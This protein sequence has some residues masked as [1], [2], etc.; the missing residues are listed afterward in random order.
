MADN[1]NRPTP[2]IPSV[3]TPVTRRL[4]FIRDTFL[5]GNPATYRMPIRPRSY[6]PELQNDGFFHDDSV[7]MLTLFEDMLAKDGVIYGILEQRRAAVLARP[8]AIIPAGQEPRD[9]EVGTFVQECL[10]H[11]GGADGGFD[12]DLYC[13]LDGIWKGVS[14]QEIEWAIDPKDKRVRP[15][16]LLHRVPANFRFDK[17]GRLFL[18]NMSVTSASQPVDDR[19]YIVFRFGGAYENPYGCGLLQRLWWYYEFKLANMRAWQVRNEKFGSPTV[20]AKLPPGVTEELKTATET[21]LERISTD[22]SFMVPDSVVVELLEAEMKAQGASDPYRNL[23]EYCDDSIARAVVGSTLTSSE[24]RRGGSLALGQVHMAVAN[25]K[26]EQDA[27]ALMWVINR[28][29]IRWIVDLNFGVDVPAPTLKIETEDPGEI[30]S[31][32]GTDQ[33]LIALGIPLSRQYFY[34]RYGRP[35]P[36]DDEEQVGQVQQPIPEAAI[37]YKTVT[38][39][40]VR[41]SMGLPD[42]PWGNDIAGSDMDLGALGANMTEED[43]DVE[44]FPS[45]ARQAPAGKQ[46]VQS[47]LFDRSKF[48]AEQARAWLKAHGYHSDGLDETENQLRFRQ[49]QPDSDHFR[50][51]PKQITPGVTLLLG[52][53]TTDAQAEGWLRRFV[54]RFASEKKKSLTSADPW[55]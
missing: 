1:A 47:V 6:Y 11:I 25:D 35:I 10:E 37:K 13:L 46:H 45:V 29:L 21:M 31:D 23:M 44:G 7:N 30:E 14:I 34:E 54:A 42:V 3:E 18:A 41:R 40:E 39:N 55:S 53:P 17:Q 43:A 4:A 12:A 15:V 2:P 48:D 8:R 26:I 20:M 5:M 50:Y 28:Q 16:N 32:L 9:L 52:F 19:K 38:K 51:R 24:G 49:V 22:T 27:R 33:K 36:A